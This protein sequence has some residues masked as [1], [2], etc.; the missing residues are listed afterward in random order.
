MFF[1]RS[2]KCSFCDKSQ[3]KVAKL[4]AGPHAYICD[5]C[6]VVASK[7]MQENSAGTVESD[8]PPSR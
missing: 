5:E 8:S 3:E 6:V 4:V 1:K 7:V 2:L